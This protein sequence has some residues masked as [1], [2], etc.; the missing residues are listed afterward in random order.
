MGKQSKKSNLKS[1]GLKVACIV[2]AVVLVLMI[3]VL[4]VL[5]KNQ[6]PGLNTD[7][8]MK[9]LNI[10]SITEQEDT[11]VVLTTYGTVK[12][13]FAFS[14]IL[15]VEAKNFDSYASLEFSVL[16]DEKSVLLYALLF[17][18]TEGMPVGTLQVDGETYEVTSQL[19]DAEDVS[20][21]DMVTIYAVQETF[22]DV[23]SSLSENSG[24]TAAG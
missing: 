2:L 1:R 18:G 9:E 8:Q 7:S 24:Y 3:V 16:I 13:P 21:D 5:L 6:G 11:M 4:A 23:L 20:D 12:Y 14:D 22:N 17:N 10:Q 15:S 19:Y